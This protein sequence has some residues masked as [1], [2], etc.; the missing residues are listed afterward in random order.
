MRTAVLPMALVCAVLAV[1][2][3]KTPRP[4]RASIDFFA[5]EVRVVCRGEERPA[6]A[7]MDLPQGCRVTTGEKSFT[8][9]ALDRGTV[10]LY[11]NT[12]V[13]L[14]LLAYTPGKS[15]ETIVLG[16]DRG[17]VLSRVTPCLTRGGG[18]SISSRTMSAGVR[19]SCF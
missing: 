5:G 1:H 13:E 16:V 14:S 3:A 19:G 9:I 6:R 11:E 7:G 8:R 10:A 17:A 15:S 4:V 2:C 12:M 18:F